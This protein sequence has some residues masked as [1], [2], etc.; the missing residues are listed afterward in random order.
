GG[1]QFYTENGKPK[2]RASAEPKPA[3]SA[4]RNGRSIA[5][6]AELLR[7][8]EADHA[9]TLAPKLLR[10]A[11]GLRVFLDKHGGEEALEVMVAILLRH[12]ID[13][14]PVNSV[15]TW[16]YFE[17]AIAEAQHKEAMREQGIRPGDAFG[18]HKKW[19]A[20]DA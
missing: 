14:K 7:L 12:A 1:T 18:T 9:K 19:S 3:R 4:A 2:F 15:K 10:D 13:G 11:E 16:R 17:D 20:G 6:N 8:A 5:K